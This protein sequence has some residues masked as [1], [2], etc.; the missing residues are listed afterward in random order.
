MGVRAATTAVAALFFASVAAVPPV[1]QPPQLNP[2]IASA[3]APAAAPH[4]AG[5]TAAFVSLEISMIFTLP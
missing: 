1:T 4:S 3:M 5:R 2:T